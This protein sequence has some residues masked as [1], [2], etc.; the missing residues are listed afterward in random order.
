MEIALKSVAIIAVVTMVLVAV[1]F[2]VLSQSGSSGTS[3]SYD[4]VF[5]TK[6]EALAQNG[7]AKTTAQFVA[8]DGDVEF[9]DACKYKFGQNQDTVTCIYLQ[10]PS[11]QQYRSEEETYCETRCNSIRATKAF[12]ANVNFD[13]FCN[14]YGNECGSYAC[15]AC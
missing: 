13:M 7:C 1:G 9:K 3:A 14:S 15:N 8:A 2:F 12:A 11:C 5:F 10:C 6:C 4:R